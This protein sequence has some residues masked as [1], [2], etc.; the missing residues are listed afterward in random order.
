MKVFNNIWNKIIIP[1]ALTST[2][3]RNVVLKTISSQTYYSKYFHPKRF[4][5]DEKSDHSRILLMQ[6]SIYLN[7][8]CLMR[9]SIVCMFCSSFNLNGT[10]FAIL[11]CL[12][13]FILYEQLWNDLKW[14]QSINCSLL[15]V[16]MTWFF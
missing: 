3:E 6:D 7:I 13:F 11:C 10:H 14:F 5:C 4:L 1:Y 8:F 15:L 9:A 16:S 12:I 2:N